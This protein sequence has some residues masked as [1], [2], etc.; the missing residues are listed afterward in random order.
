MSTKNLEE[1]FER[2]CR[3][4]LL[5]YYDLDHETGYV[6]SGC[7][8]EDDEEVAEAYDNFA[9][10]PKW[11]PFPHPDDVVTAKAFEEDCE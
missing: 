10:C 11:R 8:I 4:C 9:P 6:E 1:L 3:Q 2:Q 7:F 5:S